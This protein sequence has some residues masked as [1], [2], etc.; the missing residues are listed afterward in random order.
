MTDFTNEKILGLAYMSISHDVRDKLDRN[1][2][3]TTANLLTT[4]DE[5]LNRCGIANTHIKALD[6]LL[7]KHGL[8]RTPHREKEKA[9]LRIL[10]MDSRIGVGTLADHTVRELVELHRYRT[11]RRMYYTI[12]N[13]DFTPEVKTIINIKVIIPKPGTDVEAMARCDEEN[14]RNLHG[15][16]KLKTIALVSKQMREET[17]QNRIREARTFTRAKLQAVNH[18][19]ITLKDREEKEQE[20]DT[21]LFAG[22]II[23]HGL[24]GLH[25]KQVSWKDRATAF[26]EEQKEAIPELYVRQ[27]RDYLAWKRFT[28]YVRHTYPKEERLITTTTGEPSYAV[29]EYF[30]LLDGLQL[31]LA[32]RQIILTKKETAISHTI[33]SDPATGN[34]IYMRG[35]TFENEIQASDPMLRLRIFEEE[36]FERTDA[37]IRLHRAATAQPPTMEEYAE[38][39]TKA[40]AIISINNIEAMLRNAVMESDGNLKTVVRRE[41]KGRQPTSFDLRIKGGRLQIRQHCETS[42][43]PKMYT[44][45]AQWA[46]NTAYL[47]TIHRRIAFT[48][49]TN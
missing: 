31:P 24:D 2:I 14:E 10:T 23:R 44:S 49:I 41:G 4:D 34:R 42:A 46:E 18:G 7:A 48:E 25:P 12:A 35:I 43:Y 6:K 15:R 22:T 26:F 11:L 19:R 28:D 13:I 38:L 16:E 33:V 40:S 32:D 36:T 21:R 45:F 9:L 39:M 3:H 8:K 17:K 27:G 47:S 37:D 30:R 20:K 1:G 5:K 29:P